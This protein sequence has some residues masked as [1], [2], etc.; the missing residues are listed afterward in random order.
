MRI[1]GD[2][3]SESGGDSIV[4]MS[5]EEPFFFFGDELRW[6]SLR[7]EADP[8]RIAGGQIMLQSGRPT[9]D[10]ERVTKSGRLISIK[11]SKTEKKRKT[12]DNIKLN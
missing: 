12:K 10:R 8:A 2:G 4:A 5:S 3:D 6:L 7:G 1:D 9:L 11:E